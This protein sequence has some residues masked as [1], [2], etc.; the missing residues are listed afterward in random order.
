MAANSSCRGRYV[1]IA[2]VIVVIA[3]LWR[4]ASIEG[5][6]HRIEASYSEAQQAVSELQ[7]D[8]EQLT[9]DLDIATRSLEASNIDISRLHNELDV[10]QSKL[11]NTVIEL[12]S[13]QRDHEN[14]RQ[15][16]TSLSD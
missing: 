3:S 8:R 1:V 2:L 16:N 15:T 10:I 6:K 14:L 12:A 5:E 7:T 4:T 13:L 11:D 9:A